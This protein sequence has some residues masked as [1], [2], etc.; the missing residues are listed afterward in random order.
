MSTGHLVPKGAPST[1]GHPKQPVSED[2]SDS[3]VTVD[4]QNSSSSSKI[5]ANKSDRVG[6]FDFGNTH[7][8]KQV[9]SSEE[10][11]SAPVKKKSDDHSM[12][13]VAS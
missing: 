6:I 13:F 11:D 2:T 4:H 7:V 10:T 1:T 8:H 12:R 3:K 5:K 9:D